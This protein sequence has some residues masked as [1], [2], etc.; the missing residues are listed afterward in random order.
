MIRTGSEEQGTTAVSDNEGDKQ[1]AM[2]TRQF[3]VD[4]PTEDLAPFVPSASARTLNAGWRPYFQSVVFEVWPSC[5]VI[6]RNNYFTKPKTDGSHIWKA[7][8]VCKVSGCVN[9]QV[10]ADMSLCAE[11]LTRI[12]IVI[13]G[14]CNHKDQAVDS[15][16]V[17]VFRN[18]L[19]LRGERRRTL[20][21]WM[22]ETGQ[23]PTE[24]YYKLLSE[25]KQEELSAGH[26]T[27]SQTPKVL[28]QAMWELEKERHGYQSVVNEL[29]YLMEAFKLTLKGSCVDGYIQ[30]IGVGVFRLPMYLQQQVDA[31]IEDC[32]SEDG[33]V[34][35]ID[36]TGSVIAKNTC[37]GSAPI[38]LYSVIVGSNSFPVYDVITNRHSSDWLTQI[39][40]QFMGDV[41]RCNKGTP[42][43]PRH[44]VLDFSYALIYAVLTVFNR[45]NITEYLQYVFNVI[46]GKV[47]NDNIASHTFVSI[48]CAH[49]IKAV[50]SNLRNCKVSREQRK[51]TMVI[52]AALQRC[53]DM[54]TAVSLYRNAYVLFCA[55]R[56]TQAVLDSHQMIRRI[57]VDHEL[58][59]DTTDV[60][61][62]DETDAED[63]DDGDDET[64]QA[65]VVRD[66]VLDD[67]VL[68][69][70][71]STIK[72]QSPFTAAFAESL[73]E[74]S[75]DETSDSDVNE[76]YSRDCFRCIKRHIHLWP[77]WSAVVQGSLERFTDSDVEVDYV[78][79]RSNSAVE[80]YFKS[81]KH[82]RVGHSS[83]L[84]ASDFV[85]RQLEY[86]QGKANELSLPPQVVDKLKAQKSTSH[87][88]DLS[89]VSWR[90]HKRSK[91][92][93]SKPTR[94]EAVG[95]LFSENTP[96]QKGKRTTTATAKP[97]KRGD[98]KR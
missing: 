95:S 77:L 26:L 39:F 83:C 89:S 10:S 23:K 79:C 76:H 22:T 38:F 11:P 42:I 81:V 63:E 40:T 82:S 46:N 36:A 71:K 24:V 60:D 73:P 2:N 25:M 51:L 84:K 21:Q 13:T 20:A 4:V 37:R 66:D 65:E 61:E 69:Q 93:H 64:E 54:H 47:S 5:A 86:V 53:H 14:E 7:T 90:K 50:A 28:K 17:K 18:R 49:M 74:L 16:D 30:D 70:T 15:K 41:K 34:V 94:T 6:F 91:L 57:V 31:F 68:K 85:L 1:R 56:Q 62:E 92:C 35:H 72:S 52:F 75:D 78:P 29:G 80:S 44:V 9:V 3:H 58:Q 12:S 33:G 27:H 48:C 97:T 55:E 32:K 98:D 8:G 96:V 59:D 87:A 45:M 43:T 19:Q 88:L 67:S